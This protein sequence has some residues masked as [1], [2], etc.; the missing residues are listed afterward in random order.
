MIQLNIFKTKNFHLYFIKIIIFCILIGGSAFCATDGL[1]GWP[2]PASFT[3]LTL[4][5]YIWPSV[6]VLQVYSGNLIGK[7]LH[8][9]HSFDDASLCSI[10][11]PVT[12]FPPSWSGFFH[13]SLI[14]LQPEST[15][16]GW[17]GGPG[18]STFYYNY[19]LLYLKHL[20]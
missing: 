8:C 1:D 14:K 15:T 10:I 13:C 17:D 5:S 4:N 3:A 18:G 2:A 19:R 11:Y 20:L 6:T 9:I 7:L 12:G 16:W